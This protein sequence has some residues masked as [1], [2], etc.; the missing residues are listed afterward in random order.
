MRILAFSFCLAAVSFAGCRSCPLFSAPGPLGLQQAQAV[1]HDPYPLPDVGY[2]EPAA[3][4]RDFQ[5]PIPQPRRDRMFM[6][7]WFG[8]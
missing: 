4:P 8:R 3:R 5:D 7:G 6:D 2:E 1:V